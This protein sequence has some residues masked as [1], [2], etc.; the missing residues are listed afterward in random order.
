MGCCRDAASFEVRFA[1]HTVLDGHFSLDTSVSPSK[2]H[3]GERPLRL[4]AARRAL[5]YQP[6]GFPIFGNGCSY[7]AAK[8]ISCAGL[9]GTQSS[10]ASKITALRANQ[11]ATRKMHHEVRF[12]TMIVAY[13]FLRSIW[14]VVLGVPGIPRAN[15]GFYQ[16]VGEVSGPQQI[17]GVPTCIPAP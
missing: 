12:P 10:I 8:H 1:F 4:N 3:C 11:Y 6:I 7:Y 17:P 16:T 15:K 5:R 13:L 14:T 9:N 2:R